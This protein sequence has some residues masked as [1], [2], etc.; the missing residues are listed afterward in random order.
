M[1]IS[2]YGIRLS[3][4]EHS[5]IEMVRNWRNAN[6]IRKNMEIREL[7]QK[8]DQEIWFESV[9]NINNNYF[10]IQADNKKV[11]LIY[12]GKIDWDNNLTG[13]AGIF[14]HDVKYQESKIPVAA[15]FLL[16]DTSFLMNIEKSFI[17][18][19]SDNKKAIEFNKALGY[20]KLPNQDGIYNQTYELILAN[21]EAH[22][23][24]IRSKLFS[25]TE[26]EKINI[27]LER[28]NEIDQHFIDRLDITNPAIK[29]SFNITI[30]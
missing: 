10:I 29:K 20:Q 21:Y 19:L 28:S 1:I 14:I 8:E 27:S 26:Y 17:T 18:V 12:A 11:G 2:G 9:N 24:L 15:S 6:H 5:E 16:T 25:S 7:I 22:R 23:D 4:L 30:S 13:N 3:R